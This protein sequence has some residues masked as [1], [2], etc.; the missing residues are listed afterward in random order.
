MTEKL[1][2]Q[3]KNLADFAY[4]TSHNLRSPVSNLNTLL[5]LYE[6]E[7][8]PAEKEMLFSKFGIVINH[9]TSTLNELIEALK[10]KVNTDVELETLSFEDCFNKTVEIIAGKILQH[11]VT[12]TS[13][14]SKVNEMEYN[15]E[16]LES[17][18]LNLIGNAIKYRSPQR[19][20]VIHVKTNLTD[21]KEIVL[22]IQDNGL[23]IDLERHGS[24]MFKLHKT[25]HRHPQA[26]GVGLF[27]THAQIEALGG[28]ITVE[29]EVEVG[30]T[31]KVIFNKKS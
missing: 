19:K 1:T 29:S 22:S 30:T 8:D 12:I 6:T 13:D 24:K 20:P 4:I 15:K 9:L 25:F 27:M 2:Q 17:I 26:K 3:N 28:V 21:K 23:G 11:Q 18:F 5:S 16:Y 31:F 7:E 10:V 14:F